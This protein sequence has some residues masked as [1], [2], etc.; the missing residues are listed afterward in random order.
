MQMKLS[1]SDS[2]HCNKHLTLT[3][4]FLRK[5]KVL[6]IVNTSWNA[7]SNPIEAYNETYYKSTNLSSDPKIK[8]HKYK[9][10]ATK[11]TSLKKTT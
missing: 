8:G 11:K 4:K 3:F 9:P 6:A 10:Q 5:L 2:L 7:E 1:V